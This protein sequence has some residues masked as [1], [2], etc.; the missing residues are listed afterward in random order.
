MA[1]S[2]ESLSKKT[3]P[4]AISGFDIEGIAGAVASWLVGV[5]L[6][7]VWGPLFWLGFIGAV[8]CLL[9][10]RRAERTPP[11]AVDAVLSPCDGVIAEI[12]VQSPPAELRLS[13]GSRIRIRISSSPASTSGIHAPMAGAIETIVVEEGDPSQVFALSPDTDGLVSAFL[14][15]TSHGGDV[16]VRVAAA[17]LG[18]RIDLDVETGDAVRGGRRIGKRRLGGWCDIYLP[19]GVNCSLSSGMTLVGGETILGLWSSTKEQPPED[20]LNEDTVVMDDV[21]EEP[22]ETASKE[23]EADP[24]KDAD[25]A[26]TDESTGAHPSADLDDEDP[27]EMFARL[28]REAEKASSSD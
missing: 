3:F 17:G 21:F 4:W 24:A 20:D 1:N 5:L 16:G 6:G 19:E 10:T 8:I 18:P 25:A 27:S 26:T 14:S 23:D 28:R 7:L 12:G 11:D 22:K 9:A 13:G 2:N 15:F